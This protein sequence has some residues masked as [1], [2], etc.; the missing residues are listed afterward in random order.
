[1]TRYDSYEF[2]V[3]PFGVTNALATFYTL[4]NKIFNPYLD[5]F[6]VVYLNDI[7]IYS[8]TLKKHVGHLRKVFQILRQ[9]E[10]YVNKEKCLFAKENV[11]F[12]GH[13]IKDGKVMIDDNKVKATQE[14]D[15]LTKVPQ[16]R[17]LLG[18]VNYYRW[19][20]KGYSTR[21]APLTE[22]LKKNKA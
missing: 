18:L 14:W 5:K 7:I 6:V 10:L 16:L 15:P 13:R 1:M 21:T 11:S 17:T 12:L 20:I 4:M 8:S 3:M 2:L 19:F 9:N 22:L